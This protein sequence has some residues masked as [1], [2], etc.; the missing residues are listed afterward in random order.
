MKLTTQ[1]RIAAQ[2]LK[3][4]INRVLFDTTK[5]KEIKEAITKEDVRSLIKEGIIKAKPKKGISS[6]RSKKIKKQKRKE[7]RK[8]PGSRKGTRKARLPKKKAWMIKVRAQRKFIKS[9]RDKKLI[10]SKTYNF[11][12]KKIKGNF[13]RSRNHIKLYLNE[14]NL[15]IKK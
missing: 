5:L 6:F 11:L 9:L 8:G 10:T 13:F 15:F 2:V 7:L 4:G 1:K 12:Y 3:V 14:H